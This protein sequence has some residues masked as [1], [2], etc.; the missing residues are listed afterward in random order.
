MSRC[1]TRPVV[2]TAR[3]RLRRRCLLVAAER[4][5]LRYVDFVVLQLFRL[6]KSCVKNDSLNDLSFVLIR[7]NDQRRL[8][9]TWRCRGS[10]RR[11]AMDPQRRFTRTI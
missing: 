10:R 4:N 11:R 2:R 1:P 5:R 6:M 9:A 8:A 7:R 3:F